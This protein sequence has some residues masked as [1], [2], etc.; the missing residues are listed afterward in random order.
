M[1]EVNF[2]H[3]VEAASRGHGDPVGRPVLAR[4]GHQ[5]AQHLA[6]RLSGGKGTMDT[7]IDSSFIY[8]YIILLFF[9]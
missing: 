2:W 8:Y 7:D 5:P 1:L 3:Q 9:S 6:L 4:A